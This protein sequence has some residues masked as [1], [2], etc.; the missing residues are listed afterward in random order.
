MFELVT[1]RSLW[2]WRREICEVVLHDGVPLH[3]FHE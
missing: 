2:W 3:I 1:E